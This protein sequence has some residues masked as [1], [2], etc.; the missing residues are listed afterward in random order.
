M[1]KI[2]VL[3]GVL[4][5][6]AFG[7]FYFLTMPADKNS[8]FSAQKL[9][10][11]DKMTANEANGKYMFYAG[12]CASCHA[13]P[14][15]NKCDEPNYKDAFNLSGGRCLKTPFGTFNVPN[16][17]SDKKAGI[18][19]WSRADFIVAMRRG[20]SPKGKH[21][22]PSFPYSSYQLM[23]TQDLVDLKSFLDS[24]K[25]QKVASK[26]H[27]L[28]FPYGFR[29]GLG[30]WKKLYLSDRVFAA[31]KSESALLARGRYLV[32]GA[33]HCQEC[34]S[35]RDMFGGIIQ[36]R[37]LSG[38]KALEGEGFV[39]NL[40]NHATGLKSWTMKQ[41]AYSLESGFTPE[42]DSFGGAMVKVQENIAHLTKQDRLAIATYLKALKP[43]A[44][45][46]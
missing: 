41:I 16:I 21:Y 36:A 44:L 14:S 24:V 39:P 45:E 8:V 6:L 5:L 11:L 9:A 19:G 1:K 10:T 31:K 23:T 27:N 30:L 33:G 18:G 22:Y 37:A 34:H 25:P 26:P 28:K 12:G 13:R 15:K 20:V 42:Y 46:K 32:E 43:I 3:L 29:R 35:P 38:S 40:T 4:G 17:S 7:I 2:V